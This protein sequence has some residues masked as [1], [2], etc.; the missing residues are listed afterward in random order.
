[1]NTLL[2]VTCGVTCHR[3]LGGNGLY[4]MRHLGRK[5]DATVDVAPQADGDEFI[6]IGGEILAFDGL[7]VAH[8]PI[9]Y[10]S[11]VEAQRAM[12]AADGSKPQILDMQCAQRL[13]KL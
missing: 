10:N 11:R 5:G 4:L 6:W 3:E 7:S 13:E 12:I 1:M 2:G 8:V 9:F